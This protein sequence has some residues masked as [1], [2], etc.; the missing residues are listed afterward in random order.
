MHISN[1]C[2]DYYLTG[3]PADA[4]T[5]PRTGLVL[6][7]GGTDQDE[8]MRFLLDRS[9][10][11][12]IVVIRA[13][14]AD[15]YND[16]LANLPL[17]DGRRVDSVETFCVKDRQGSFDP[18]LLE[19]LEKAEGIFFAGGDQYKY[20]QLFEGTPLQAA[21][22]KAYD[23]GVPIG[24]TSAGLALLGDPIFSAERDTIDSE[25]ALQD[26]FGPKVTLAERFLESEPLENV[27]TDTHFSERERMGRLLVFMSREPRSKGLGVDEA[28][29]VLVDEH[30]KGLVVGQGSAY[31]ASLPEPPT[32]EP[33]QPLNL[34][35]ADVV[36]CDSG[37]TFDLLAWR[38]P[39]G[40]R[41]VYRVEHGKLQAGASEP[42][43]N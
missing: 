43:E 4:V 19:R 29:A 23:R 18:F 39:D 1:P 11:G 38:S 2:Y 30:G 31:F 16:Y 34:K 6:A 7:G 5:R 8:A 22:Q 21:V 13:S 41:Q 24:G 27:V 12:D 36:K 15:G 42:A 37:Q 33:G 35:R 40:T 28:T 17:S 9:D 10:G 14:G 20:L 32:L 3:N 25:E 26:P